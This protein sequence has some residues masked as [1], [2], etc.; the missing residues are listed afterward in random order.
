MV[1][2]LPLLSY[3]SWMSVKENPDRKKQGLT[4]SWIML[5]FVSLTSTKKIHLPTSVLISKS[6]SLERRRM[7]M[8]VMM[9]MTN[10]FCELFD[11]R[12]SVKPDFLLGPWAGFLFRAHFQHATSRVWTCEESKFQLCRM[13]WKAYNTT[14]QRVVVLMS[15]L[16]KVRD[17]AARIFF[18][19]IGKSS[20]EI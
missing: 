2:S 18:F 5:R 19:N 3:E 17:I 4:L 11:R 8:K 12:K 1:P 16:L 7:M 15:P 10:C 6:T 13:K 14:F 20:A 9:L